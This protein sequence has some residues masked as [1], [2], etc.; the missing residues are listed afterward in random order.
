MMH[1]KGLC[2]HINNYEAQKLH[3]KSRTPVTQTLKENGKQ[4]ELA[5]NSSLLEGNLV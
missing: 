4:F 5:G 1:I 3:N 2:K